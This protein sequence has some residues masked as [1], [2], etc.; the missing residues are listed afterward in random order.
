MS[1]SDVYDP[2][3]TL[4]ETDDNSEEFDGILPRMKALGYS[5]ERIGEI[6]NNSKKIDGLISDYF[7]SPARDGRYHFYNH[8]KQGME[9]VPTTILGIL[10][11]LGAIDENGGFLA[12]GSCGELL[13]TVF[14]EEN[15][16]AV[17]DHWLFTSILTFSTVTDY[18]RSV[19]MPDEYYSMSAAQ[20][21][22]SCAQDVLCEEYIRQYIDDSTFNEISELAEE[23]KKSAVDTVYNAEWLSTHGKELARRKILKMRETIGRNMDTNNLSDVELADNAVD[24]LISLMV[25]KMHFI[26]SQVPKE[27]ADRDIFDGD[28]VDVNARYNYRYNSLYLCTGLLTEF[29]EKVGESYEERMGHIGKILAHEIS[30]A[31]GPQG[32][33]FDSNGWYEPWLTE[34]EQAAYAKEVMALTD[35]F[36]GKEDEYG[37]KISGEQI[38]NETYADILAMKICLKLLSQKEGVDY[39]KFFRA[40]AREQAMYYSKEGYGGL[41]DAAKEYLG[42]KLRINY[43]YGQFDK[44]YETYDIDE[45][46]PFFVPEDK[47]I[48]LFK[49]EN[50]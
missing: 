33:S 10:K 46:S 24:N 21:I 31:Y 28:M 29:Q 23:V 45:S 5:K 22:R 48:K 12:F 38:A 3:L 44:F 2:L 41:S 18:N 1:L 34:E 32:I 27:D 9:G 36:D 20:I 4:L 30:H 43:V 42:G 15:A 11:D 14:T 35:F 13:N 49:A 8:R 40:A 39:D 37:N 17:R 7:N 50:E 26:C 19:E 25:S 16:A 6:L 47:R